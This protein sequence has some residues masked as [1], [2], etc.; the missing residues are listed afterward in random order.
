MN[1]KDHI[2]LR[3][4]SKNLSS[5]FFFSILCVCMIWLTTFT[6]IFYFIQVKQVYYKKKLSMGLPIKMPILKDKH[7]TRC[8]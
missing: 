5:F 4:M 2:D 3:T 7:I 1:C 6:L 8:F